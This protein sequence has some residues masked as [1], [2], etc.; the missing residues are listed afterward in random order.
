[1]ITIIYELAVL[2]TKPAHKGIFYMLRYELIFGEVSE[3]IEKN[4]SDQE[5]LSMLEKI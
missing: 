4:I 5:L 1:L 2:A 3:R